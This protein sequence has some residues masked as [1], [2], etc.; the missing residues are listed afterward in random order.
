MKAGT[1]K[2]VYPIIAATVVVFMAV[3]LLGLTDV[4]VRPMIELQRELRTERMLTEIFPEMDKFIYEADIYWIYSNEVKIGFAFLARGMGYGG[5]ID[6]LV[7]LENE[8]IKGIGIVTHRETPGM[9]DRITEPEFKD[10]FLGLYIGDAALKRDDGRIDA[11]TGAT[12]SSRAVA[13]AVREM[14]MEKIRALEGR[15]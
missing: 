8:T 12:I 15:E 7:G 6:I 1:L 10:Q 4:M 5:H 14:A 13:E 3:T 2:K 9:G 11:I